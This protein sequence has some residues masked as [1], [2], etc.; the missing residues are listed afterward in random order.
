M[1][2][3]FSDRYDILIQACNNINFLYRNKRKYENA[4]EEN[5]KKLKFYTFCR[6]DLKGQ[7][8]PYGDKNKKAKKKNRS[9]KPINAT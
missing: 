8:N 9:K 7:D 2:N 4:S 6:N 5:Q 3:S 1:K